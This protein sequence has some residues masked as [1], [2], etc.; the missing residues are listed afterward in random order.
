MSDI[1]PMDPFE[2]DRRER[3]FMQCEAEGEQL[4]YLLRHTDIRRA[5]KD[6][7]TF[8]S[9]APARVPVPAELDIRTY[10]QLPIETDP[11]THAKL[12]NIVEPFF[13]KPMQADYIAEM[14]TLIARLL[15]KVI[16]KGPFEFV[17]CFALPLQS[18]ALTML[19]GAPAEDAEEFVSWGVNALLED[20][21]ISNAKAQVVEAYIHRRLDASQV[22]PRDDLF[23]ALTAATFEERP[24]SRTEMLGFVHLAL[25]GGRETVIDALTGSIAYL[26]ANPEAF[27]RLKEA[28]ELVNSATEEFI[29]WI[30]PLTEI[31]RVATVD[32]K[33]LGQDV[34]RDRRIALCW[35]SANRD[36]AIFENANEVQLDR[37]PNPHI[38]F[39]SGAHSCLGS[40]H[41][42]L[43]MRT[44][45]AQLAMT[46]DAVE[47]LEAVPKLRSCPQFD[48]Q[49]GYER[50]VVRFKGEMQMADMASKKI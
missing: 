14:Q 4:L 6:W 46:V 47:V 38:A 13:R 30:S 12:R 34:K 2:K 29:R 32:T 42:R 44:V 16:G 40:A 36:E 21:I 11:P 17:E 18:Q 27:S 8:S 10:R 50:L 49:V 7:N 23:S 15:N 3:G 37:S 22:N 28:P 41:A 25:A 39:G 33:A 48:R 9:D 24:L 20:G 43:I 35:A 45:L 19:L 5:A 26:G 1:D 31:G